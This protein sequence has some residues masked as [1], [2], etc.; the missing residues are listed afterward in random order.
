MGSF[1]FTLQVQ[2]ALGQ[3]DAQAFTLT[4]VDPL[5]VTVAGTGTAGFSGDGAAATA[6]MLNRPADIVVDAA[7]NLLIADQ[8]NHRIRRVDALTGVITTVA[9][10]G[11]GGFAGDGGPAT[12]AQL[13]TAQGMRTD[14]AGNLLIADS[15]NHRIRRVDALTGFIS[16]VAGDGTGT[17][18]GDGGVAGDGAGGRPVR[19]ADGADRWQAD[20]GDRVRDGD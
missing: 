7:G 18:S 1:G 4:V 10:T 16:T 5:I 19:R 6:A 9:G 11:A 3:T 2:D 20:A 15:A 13:N 8:L 14:A 12:A 17:F